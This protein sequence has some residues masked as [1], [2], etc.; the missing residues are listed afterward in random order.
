VPVFE[1]HVVERSVPVME[2]VERTVVAEPFGHR[3]TVDARSRSPMLHP[4]SYAGYHEVSR[5]SAATPT[6][7]TTSKK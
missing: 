6:V 5:L 4:S 1:D 7:Q 2:R 3:L